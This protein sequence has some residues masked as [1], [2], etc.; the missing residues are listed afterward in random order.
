[1]E[2]C[3]S[4]NAVAAYATDARLGVWRTVKVGMLAGV[5]TQAPGIQILGRSGGG[6]EDPALVAAP[7]HM[8]LARAVARLA[9]NAGMHLGQLAVRIGGKVFGL[10]FVAGRAGFS[11]HKIA[12]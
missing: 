3:G 1:M 5:A 11:A 8:R 4:V 6:V 10:R 9:G 2:N 7:F 12:G